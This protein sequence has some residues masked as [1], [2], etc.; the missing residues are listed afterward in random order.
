LGFLSITL[1]EGVEHE[2]SLDW[3]GELYDGE[4]NELQN[5]G[6]QSGDIYPLPENW[7]ADFLRSQRPGNPP[8]HEVLQVVVYGLQSFCC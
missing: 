2:T 4:S 1:K 6:L 7:C 8:S 5:I 3:G